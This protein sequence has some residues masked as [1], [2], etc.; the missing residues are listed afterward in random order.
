[1]NQSFTNLLPN[2][3]WRQKISVRS[4]LRIFY[5]ASTNFPSVTQ[6]QD[7]V[8]Q[9]NQLRMSIGNPNLKQS[10]N[11]FLSGRYTFT[12]TQKGQ[13][14]F[15]NI[16][17]QAQQDYISNATY[18]AGADSVIQQDVTLA[19]GSQ[20]TKPVNLNGYKS[21]RSF[22]TFSQPVKFIKSNI[23]LSTG[24]SYSKLP[25]LINQLKSMTDNYI[26]NAGIVIASNVSEY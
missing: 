10:Y 25:A 23:N 11:H 7:V 2:L 16:F 21:F 24:F 9:S 14:F 19:K 17:L 5:R 6:L 3:Q 22:F 26:Y 12:N 15:A 13:A 4:N 18:I 20:L 1:V 8:N